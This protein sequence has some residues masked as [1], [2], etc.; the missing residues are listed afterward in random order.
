MAL[1]AYFIIGYAVLYRA[2]V[3]ERG[4][5]Y[6]FKSSSFTLQIKLQTELHVSIEELGR[7]LVNDQDHFKFKP[8]DVKKSFDTEQH[9]GKW[10][11]SENAGKTIYKLIQKDNGVTVVEKYFCCDMSHNEVLSDLPEVKQ[12]LALRNH[13]QMEC[14]PSKSSEAAIH[15]N[16]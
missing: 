11:V 1:I 5:S 16:L 13:V 12:L 7:V 9:N 2:E 6:I 14:A 4:I 8:G 10:F 15:M 3:Y